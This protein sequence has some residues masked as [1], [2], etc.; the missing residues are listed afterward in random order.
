[1]P[2]RHHTP[3]DDS[4]NTVLHNGNKLTPREWEKVIRA[5]PTL[6]SN[7]ESYNTVCSKMCGINGSMKNSS[8]CKKV[9]GACKDM[10][11]VYLGL[12]GHADVQSALARHGYDKSFVGQVILNGSIGNPMNKFCMEPVNSRRCPNGKKCLTG[13]LE[14][15]APV[16]EAAADKFGLWMQPTCDAHTSSRTCPGKGGCS[17]KDTPLYQNMCSHVNPFP[18]H[19]HAPPDHAKLIIV[20]V[21]LLLVVFFVRTVRSR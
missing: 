18:H 6:P 19:S 17:Q 3:I 15:Y 8:L 12:V 16:C 4:P 20:I 9:K 11:K 10:D 5:G 2:N 13:D 21:G 1:M 7:P 14:Q